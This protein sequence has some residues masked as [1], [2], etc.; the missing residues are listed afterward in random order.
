MALV[1]FAGTYF[2]AAVVSGGTTRLAVNE[3]SRVIDPG[4]LSPLGL[5]FGLLLFSPPPSSGVISNGRA[6]RSPPKR[7]ERDAPEFDVWLRRN[8]SGLFG[9]TMQL[10]QQLRGLVV[11]TKMRD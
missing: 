10:P 5:V 9:G 3:R 8:S 11:G 7:E 1:I 4:M 6:A 2:I